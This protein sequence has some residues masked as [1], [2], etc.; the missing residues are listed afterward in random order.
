MKRLW[1]W[2]W[3][4]LSK[5]MRVHIR[6]ANE[7]D[8][9]RE[10]IDWLYTGP[11]WTAL[12][13]ALEIIQY[14]AWTFN[15]QWPDVL[16]NILAGHQWTQEEESARSLLEETHQALTHMHAPLLDAWVVLAGGRQS[17]LRVRIP[18]RPN[19]TFF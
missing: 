5:P 8:M 2:L 10:R 15:Q 6:I 18:A 13:T 17:P 19:P 11:G 14:R 12:I 7:T 16:G 1:T 3:K 4:Q 9:G